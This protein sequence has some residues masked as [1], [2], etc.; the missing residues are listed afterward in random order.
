MDSQRPKQER[1]NQIFFALHVRLDE[2]FSP[3][4]EMHSSESKRRK[5][6][7]P[8]TSA[9][10][11]FQTIAIDELTIAF[12]GR[13]NAKQCNKQKPHKLGFK[14]FALCDSNTGFLLPFK[15]YGGK[16]E[17]RPRDFGTKGIFLLLIIGIQ[18]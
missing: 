15:M 9:F 3:E 13:H 5:K 12:K 17:D 2:E 11:P 18:V 6:S 1:F 10:F 8:F 14:N 7:F 4:E 16:D